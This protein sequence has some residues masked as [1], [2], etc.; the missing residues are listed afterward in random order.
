VPEARVRVRVRVVV[1]AL[2]QHM[3]LQRLLHVLLL[4][5]VG[6]AS[7]IVHCAGVL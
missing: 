6:P 7:A 4:T 5:V 2:A 1:A 3:F